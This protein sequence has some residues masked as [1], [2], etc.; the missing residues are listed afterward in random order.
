MIH[1]KNLR[2]YTLII[3]LLVRQTT[4][5]VSLPG[6]QT[7]GWYAEFLSMLPNELRKCEGRNRSDEGFLKVNVAQQKRMS[8]S[9]RSVGE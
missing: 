6:I 9:C 1:K 2:V 5:C 3:L 8:M 7:S 4:R